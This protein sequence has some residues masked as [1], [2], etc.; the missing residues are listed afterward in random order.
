MRFLVIV[1]FFP[2]T[3]VVHPVRLKRKLSDEVER[4]QIL[5]RLSENELSVFVLI[6]R[7]F[8]SL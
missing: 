6:T 3:L 2:A 4:R 5:N 1:F 7:Q 8:L